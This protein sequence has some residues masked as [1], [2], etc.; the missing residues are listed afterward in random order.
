MR[1]G[2]GACAARVGQRGGE[3][4]LE[5]GERGRRKRPNPSS[6]TSPAPTSFPGRTESLLISQRF[7]SHQESL[8]AF[9]GLL[10]SG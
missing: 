2:W 8:D 3:P 9:L 6:S 5:I 7:A 1:R 4:R 10:S